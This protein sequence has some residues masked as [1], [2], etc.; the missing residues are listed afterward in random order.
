MD[1]LRIDKAELLLTLKT[2]NTITVELGPVI[3]NIG[4]HPPP[5][6]THRA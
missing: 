4:D 3:Q 2:K 6:T 1:A 5:T